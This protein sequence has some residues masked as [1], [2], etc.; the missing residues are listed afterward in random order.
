[1][2]QGWVRTEPEPVL[3]GLRC[4][5]CGTYRFPPGCAWCPNPGCGSEDLEPAGLSRRGRIWSYTDARYQPPA[6]YVPASEPYEPFAIAAVA[7]EKE[8][9]VVLGQV[10][11]GFGV[12][13]LRVGQEAEVVVEPLPGGP[14]GTLVWR[15]LP[16]EAAD[17]R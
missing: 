6:P 17:E 1:M 16:L 4:R 5:V 2:M 13:D 7:L 12:A 11:A 8:R 3:V 15:W 9:M 14:D 10:A